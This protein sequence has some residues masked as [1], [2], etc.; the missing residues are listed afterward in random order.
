MNWSDWLGDANEV[1]ETD[2]I[3]L[4]QGRALVR[5]PSIRKMLWLPA[6][7]FWS[8]AGLLP[9]GV[10]VAGLGGHV[11]TAGSV[12]S[13]S[14]ASASVASAS[15]ASASVASASG[16]AT[17]LPILSTLL[18]MLSLRG[19]NS[20]KTSKRGNVLGVLGALTGIGSAI[21]LAPA[22]SSSTLT[23]AALTAATASVVGLYVANTTEMEQMPELVAAFH[24]F[25]GLAAVL[26]GG[27]AFF[28]HP[29]PTS[30]AH[31]LETFIG[32]AVGAATFT[33]SLVAAGKL[34]G[35]LPGRPIGISARN[36]AVPLSIVILGISGGVYCKAADFTA[37][38]LCLVGN[39]LLS[40]SIGTLAVLPVGGADMPVIVSLLNSLSGLATSAAGF[41]LENNL[42]V[43]TGA[44]VASSGALLSDVMCR[45]IN[46]SMV[47]V[48]MGGFGGGDSVAASG[49]PAEPVVEISSLGLVEVLKESRKIL[50]VP[51]YGLAVARCQS[52]IAEIAKMLRSAGKDVVFGI[53]P[54][55]GRLPGHMD[56][57][58]AE[59][60]VPYDIVQTLEEV[61]REISDYDVAIVLGANDIVNPATQSDQ[62][63]PIYGMPAIE[64]WKAKSCV[65]L[66]RSMATGYSGVENPLF[67]LQETRMLF[68]DAKRS[69]EDVERALIDG[70][71]EFTGSG[72]QGAKKAVVVFPDEMEEARNPV[73]SLSTSSKTIGIL[74]ESTDAEKRVACSPKVVRKLIK[75]GFQV[76]YESDAGKA[77]GWAD[78]EF[79]AAGAI[80]LTNAKAV[81]QK[82]DIV[83]KINGIN[84]TEI[85]SSEK[86]EDA[87]KI[88]IAVSLSPDTYSSLA[89]QRLT[90]FNLSLVPR[91]SRAQKLDSL[92]SM[93]NIAGYRAVIEA[94]HLLPRF[95]RTSAT[96]CGKLPAANVFV[97][98]AGVAGLSA[99]ATAKALGCNVVAN[100]V[101]AACKEQVE[102]MGARFLE[103]LDESGDP[104]IQG[105]GKGGYATE[106]ADAFALAQ[107]QTYA[108]ALRNA[109]VVICSAMIPGKAAPKLIS[110]EMLQTMK[111]DAVVVDLA[112]PG[113][114]NC[115]LTKTGE[116][117]FEPVNRVRVIGRTNF[118]SDMPQQ[119]S[120]LLGHN[121]LSFLELL[122]DGKVE[123]SDPIVR[124]CLV[125]F[126]GQVAFPPPPMPSPVP[127]ATVPETLN[128]IDPENA[129]VAEFLKSRGEEFAV[130]LGLGAMLLLG[131]TADP[132]QVKLMGDF[133][134]SVLIGNFTV[135]SVAP[136]LHTPL[137][138]V[139]NAISGIIVVGGVVQL[140]GPLA[141]GK[142]ICSLLSVFF[143][144]VNVTGGFAVSQRMLEMFKSE[145]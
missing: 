10:T 43:M 29:N 61:N 127:A 13:A 16:L 17:G 62:N 89:R 39:V 81:I 139:T 24:S 80:V 15:V 132:R 11:I 36:V 70:L 64:V 84:E 115:E 143:S 49:G 144:L 90:A 126:D 37:R 145:N 73:L 76:V 123:I 35:I 14:V 141:S 105:E 1:R 67:H 56:V 96:A 77:A 28:A 79:L 41:M 117:V 119:S 75:S 60:S 135:A 103:I 130:A 53:H 74:N 31:S 59:A 99:I 22:I 25:T 136:A 19:L 129:A 48:V 114:G 95:S 78:S 138:S 72:L 124:Q 82:A 68:G 30:I 34:H 58:L 21:I 55:A 97:I 71:A 98:G 54:V 51:G 2:E 87:E 125:T 69:L 63:S 112:A 104:P 109:D 88:F 65:V 12:A 57:L 128:P 40:G 66:K 8:K 134:L 45:G 47:N 131:L 91:I 9:F 18:F 107:K 32:V 137:I 140:S 33:G 85:L 7:V 110:K 23:A 122:G 27:G 100:D 83:L 108:Q 111:P 118:T 121:F 5:L 133:I 42:L 4:A 20:H 52:K 3:K 142:V 92:T 46:R 50:I 106:L 113:G 6:A 44:L 26:V 120:D 116:T 101:R 38:G 86:P 102:S 93:A 94:L